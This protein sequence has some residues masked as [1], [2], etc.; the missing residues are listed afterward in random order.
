MKK[1]ITI[2]IVVVSSVLAIPFAVQAKEG[3]SSS[4]AASAWGVGYSVQ[5]NDDYVQ[6]RDGKPAEGGGAKE[7]RIYK[8]N[9][10]VAA[11]LAFFLGGVGGHSFYMGHTWTGIIRLSATVLTGGAAAAILIPISM[12]EACLYLFSSDAEFNEKYIING[13]SWF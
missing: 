6:V 4:G 9:R 13:Q 7:T 10:F 1:L 2:A 5:D 8:K 12:I 11:A 3:K